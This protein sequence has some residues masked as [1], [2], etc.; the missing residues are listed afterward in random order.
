MQL[1]KDILGFNISG[2]GSNTLCILFANIVEEGAWLW[3]ISGGYLNGTKYETLWQALIHKR[4]KNYKSTPRGGVPHVNA[5]TKI[6]LAG[7]VI[8]F[9]DFQWF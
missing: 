3:R 1:L 6:Y 7:N 9:D 4:I 8:S 5:Q 2:L